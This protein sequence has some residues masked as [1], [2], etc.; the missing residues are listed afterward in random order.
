MGH[1][2]AVT[3]GKVMAAVHDCIAQVN[4]NTRNV[5]TIREAHDVLAK[6]VD[7]DIADLKQGRTAQG[8]WCSAN[9]DA[10]AKLR[11]EIAE[12]RAITNLAH[13]R[14]EVFAR[15][16]RQFLHGLTRWQRLVWVFTGRLPRLEEPISG[17]GW[18]EPERS[19]FTHE[20][21]ATIGSRAAAV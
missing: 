16:G 20:A 10:I 12:T 19:A 5:A 8:Q 11:K 3:K 17:E 18:T 15:H 1:E 9:E 21:E 7:A 13:D 14:I 2:A 4:S 6:Q